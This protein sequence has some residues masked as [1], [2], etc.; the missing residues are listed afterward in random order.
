M[1]VDIFFT[2]KFGKTEVYKLP[3]PII[4][5]SASRIAVNASLNGSA[6]SGIII[7]F[8]ILVFCAIASS[9]I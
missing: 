9:G 4:I 6:F 5:T 8:E 2:N 7:N 1:V 3:G